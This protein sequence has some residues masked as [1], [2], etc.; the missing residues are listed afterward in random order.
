[1]DEGSSDTNMN[2]GLYY[3]KSARMWIRFI[4]PSICSR[5]GLSTNQTNFKFNK[6]AEFI[7]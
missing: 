2:T 1:M 6:G 3:E 4:W 5:D 7:D